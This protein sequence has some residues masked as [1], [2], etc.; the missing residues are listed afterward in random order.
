[1]LG[2]AFDQDRARAFQRRL[3]VGHALGLIHEGRAAALRVVRRV[4][5]QKIGQRLQ[6]GLAGD[7]RLGAA[8]GLVGKI[9]VFEPRLGVG[10]A[11]LDQQLVRQLALLADAF[12]DRLAAL[13]QFAQVSQALVQGAQLRIVEGPGDFLAVAG[14]ER[15]RRA[16]IQQVDGGLHL[17]FLG[18]QFLGDALA[19]GLHRNLRELRRGFYGVPAPPVNGGGLSGRALPLRQVISLGLG[20]LPG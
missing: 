15:N 6:P 7:L 11:Q 1:M 16:R 2:E 19:D 10:S 3:H 12:E 8:F 9:E 18:I 14:D 4:V 5:E 17:P 13:L 20:S